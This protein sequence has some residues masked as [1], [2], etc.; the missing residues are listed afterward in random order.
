MGLAT[1]LTILS[2][3]G[4]LC[5]DEMAFYSAEMKASIDILVRFVGLV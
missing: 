1:D 3:K 4:R 5:K 2:V